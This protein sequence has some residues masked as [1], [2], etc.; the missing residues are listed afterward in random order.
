MM[1]LH[2]KRRRKKK[3]SLMYRWMMIKKKSNRLT[4]KKLESHL[5]IRMTIILMNK[6]KKKKMVM[7]KSMKIR[8]KRVQESR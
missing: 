8:C 6:I 4:K 3:K 2:R 5:W 7:K 1:I